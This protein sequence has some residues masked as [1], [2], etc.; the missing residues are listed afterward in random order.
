MTA[1]NS[2]VATSASTIQ[3]S[4]WQCCYLPATDSLNFP[5]SEAAWR[6]AVVPGIASQSLT[7]IASTIDDYEIWYRCSWPAQLASTTLVFEGLAGL[8]E[9]Y[10]DQQQLLRS[11]TMFK[12]HQLSLPAFTASPTYLYLRCLPLNRHLPSKK[13]RPRWKTRL[14]TQQ[15]WRWLRQSLLGRMPGWSAHDAPV[16]PYRPVYWLAQSAWQLTQAQ[17]ACRLQQG[18]GLL[19]LQATLQLPA[20]LL[21]EKL[22]ARLQLRLYQGATA[23][24][25]CYEFPLE[26]ATSAEAAS[27]QISAQLSLP[28]V[29]LWWPH[30]H[31]QA[32]RYAVLL[33]I[34][35]AA[36]TLFQHDLGFCAFRDLSPQTASGFQVRLNQQTIF[37]RGACWTPLPGL[38][39]E[40]AAL[41]HSLELVKAAG[42]N[43]L[44]VVGT[45]L[46]ESAMFYQLCDELGIMVWQDCVFANL[47]YPFQ[48]ADFLATACAEVREF[49]L[50][51]RRYASL[52]ML[53]GNSE[54]EQQAAMLGMP[55][56]LWRAEFFADTLPAL[57]R[58]LHPAC[59]YTPSSPA[60]SNNNAWPFQ[61]NAGIAHYFG[62]GAYLRPLS[63]ARLAGVQFTS[64]SLGFA[65]L[66]DE[67]Y[68]E[69]QFAPHLPCSTYPEWKRGIPRDHGCQWDFEDVR[70]HYLQLLFQVSPSQLRSSDNRRYRQLS[71]L[72]SGIAMAHCLYEWRRPGSACQGALLW[73]WR[74][75][76]AGAGW[77]LLDASGNPKA[78][79]Y[80]VKRALQAQTGWI[81]DEGLNGLCCHLINEQAETLAVRLL[82]RVIQEDGRVLH[83]TERSLQLP[84]HSQ[85]SINDVELLP[86]FMDA[87]YAYRFGPPQHLAV[88]LC[89][90]HDNGADTAAAKMISQ[91]VFLARGWSQLPALQ[92]ANWQLDLRQDP[93]QTDSWLL[94]L[95]CDQAAFAV[96]LDLPGFVLSD[97]YFDLLPGTPRQ[98]R[99]QALSAGSI[100]KG[101]VQA[102][103]ATHSLRLP[104]PI[105]ADQETPL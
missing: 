10:A 91:S 32:Q 1:N 74:D 31:G 24:D 64:E 96:A 33:Q 4:D 38:S 20:R 78:A 103:N 3:A 75:L 102:L 36:Q 76:L 89:L 71:R 85:L 40:P 67:S 13:P 104:S 18:T 59:Y 41:R 19:D 46:Y 29:A 51:Q 56:E 25:T 26:L 83:Q 79:Y 42:M 86:Q 97:N 92:N 94:D 55:R 84:P 35:D 99:I 87:S 93:S 49:I 12:R 52:V 88:Q 9:V 65:N 98:I 73:F 81:S 2:A 37:C 14:V 47:D 80:F 63:D 34:H 53:C 105:R 43:M 21:A 100:P 72:T 44:R 28:E 57:L 11:D 8:V 7:E 39:A 60:T 48:D 15:G 58:E 82:Y 95:A 70:D 22:N 27:L 23:S 69:Q 66:P 16:G 61:V 54:I 90:Y 68:L 50:Q 62:V 77:G 6:S 17:L 101:Q 5:G 30:S 45:M